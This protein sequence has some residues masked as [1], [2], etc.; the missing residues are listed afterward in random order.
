LFIETRKNAPSDPLA[1][2]IPSLVKYVIAFNIQTFPASEGIERFPF[3]FYKPHRQ[4]NV[5]TDTTTSGH[6]H[7][8]SHEAIS[9]A[10]ASIAQKG[11]STFLEGSRVTTPSGRAIDSRSINPMLRPVVG[12]YESDRDSKVKQNEEN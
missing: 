8:P 12:V 10:Q 3:A 4:V 2:V 9:V 1:W 5:S 7:K 6:L 11:W